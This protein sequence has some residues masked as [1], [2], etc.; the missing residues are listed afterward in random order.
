MTS[1]WQL[2]KDTV[3]ILKQPVSAHLNFAI[4]TACN[5][6]GVILNHSENSLK[7]KMLQSDI[8]SLNVPYRS[9][10][11]CSANFCHKEKSWIVAIEKAE[12][13]KL[14]DKYQQNAIFWVEAN[15]LYLTPCRL[16][17]EMYQEEFIG[18]FNQRIKLS[19]SEVAY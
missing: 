5:P 16:M 18:L 1:V 11:G 4:I 8:L 19:M 14:A 17:A 7:D 15:Q 12:A 13:I 2:Y 6:N 3:F 10:T 9:I